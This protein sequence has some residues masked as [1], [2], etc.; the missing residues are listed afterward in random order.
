MPQFDI[1][2]EAGDKCKIPFDIM[3]FKEVVFEMKLLEKNRN[4]NYSNLYFSIE[5][6]L[7]KVDF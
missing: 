3:T 1:T 6:Y 4:E 5:N 7:K 2:I